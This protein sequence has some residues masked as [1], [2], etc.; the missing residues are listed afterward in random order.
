MPALARRAAHRLIRRGR[1]P[2][3]GWRAPRVP[4]VVEKLT[5]AF[6]PRYRAI[7]Q[8][9]IRALS[10]MAFKLTY[11]DGQESEHDDD[12][13][14][15]IDDGVLMLGRE[16][17]KWSVYLSPS[18]W[19]VLEVGVSKPKDKDDAETDDADDSD[20]DDS[21]EDDKKDSAKKDDSE[22]A[23]EDEDKKEKKDSSDD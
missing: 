3:P 2:P 12:T 15:E 6:C 13:V 14:W 1:K 8:E 22:D 23:D 18:H 5:D 19:A 11:S 20:T 10:S 4:F 9:S 7:N 17:D 21:D 16:K